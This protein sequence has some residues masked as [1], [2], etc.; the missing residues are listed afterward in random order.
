MS[1]RSKILQ[2]KVPKEERELHIISNPGFRPSYQ[3]DYQAPLTARTLSPKS[4]W[5]IVR[6]NLHRIRSMDTTRKYSL[7]DPYDDIYLFCQTRR[8]LRRV[9]K[10]IQQVEALPDFTPIHYFEIS[11]DERH[12]RRYD[13]GHVQPKDALFY[14][15]YGL[16]PFGLQAL[17][18]YFSAR[19]PIRHD[20]VFQPFISHVCGV[21][22]RNE[23]Y[24]HRVAVL[25]RAAAI[26]AS[27]VYLILAL[28]FFT[29][30]FSVLQTIFKFH[31]FYA[32]NPNGDI[33]WKSFTSTV[34]SY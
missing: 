23:Q 21:V 31:A 26:M 24:Q 3:Y 12:T 16:E 2:S 7:K 20:S 33:E 10:Q 9:Q 25:R 8:E 5:I 1:Y 32:N 19:E 4:K 30:I 14:P 28:M 27:I 15:G 6:N 34:N 22:N 13:V 29:L 18:Y 11:T 17:F